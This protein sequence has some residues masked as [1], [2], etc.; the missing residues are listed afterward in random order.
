MAESVTQTA[1]AEE[2]NGVMIMNT[3]VNNTNAIVTE[4]TTKLSNRDRTLK[5]LFDVICVDNEFSLLRRTL[6]LYCEEIERKM[7]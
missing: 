7:N 3:D 6:E 2:G 5:T 4:T 1:E